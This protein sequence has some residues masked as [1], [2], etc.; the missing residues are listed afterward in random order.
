VGATVDAMT[1][2]L[3]MSVATSEAIVLDYG[4]Q[5]VIRSICPADAGAL[6]RF[7][8][9]LSS[10]S[11]QQRYFYPH[12]DL[13]SDE[14]AHLTQ[15]DGVDRVALVVEKDEE[16]IAVGRYERLTEPRA[17]EVAFVVADAY[18]HHGLATMLFSHLVKAARS[19][20]I[21]RFVAEVLA[22][23]RPMLSVFREAGFPI[24]SRTEWGTVELTMTIAPDRDGAA[25]A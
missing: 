6:L 21:T 17:A 5:V 4:T 24:E 25:D 14:V 19:V 11:I 16:L 13:G 2:A 22:A 18:Q 20:G 12:T 7:H 10:T 3:D 15:V 9:T 23:N 1:T 8:A